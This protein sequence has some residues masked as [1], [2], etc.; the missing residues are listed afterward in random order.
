MNTFIEE[1]LGWYILQLFWPFV[2]AF[3]RY[4]V[5]NVIMRT[6]W[7]PNHNY[8]ETVTNFRGINVLTKKNWMICLK[9]AISKGRNYSSI[10]QLK[11]SST[12][13]DSSDYFYVSF[14]S[15]NKVDKYKQPISFV[16]VLIYQYLPA[17]VF[18]MC[19]TLPPRGI[20]PR[21]DNIKNLK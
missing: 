14:W 1:F 12:Y 2:I 17:I 20:L 11:H 3:F 16:F 5:K 6:L 7:M 18:I 21:M 10:H 9:E 13:S 15:S 8:N 19:N 4:A